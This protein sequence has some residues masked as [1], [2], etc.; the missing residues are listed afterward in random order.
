MKITSHILGLGLLLAPPALLG[1]VINAPHSPVAPQ[2]DGVVSPEEW[3]DAAQSY[4][5]IRYGK[6]AMEEAPTRLLVK[7][8]GDN[9]YIAA[10]CYQPDEPTCPVQ[11]RDVVMWLDDAVEFFLRPDLAKPD[12][13]HFSVNAIGNVY[14]AKERDNSWNSDAW[15]VKTSQA[16]GQW[17]ME[18]M[19]PAEV[20]GLSGGFPENCELGFNFCRNKSVDKS[21]LGGPS[22]C[23]GVIASTWTPY[24]SNTWHDPES[25]G[26][27]SGRTEVYFQQDNLLL[28]TASGIRITGTLYNPTDRAIRV[29]AHLEAVRHDDGTIRQSD[30]EFEVPA[31]ASLP[32]D[33]HADAGIGTWDGSFFLMDTASGQSYA[34]RRFRDLLDTDVRV[35]KFWSSEVVEAFYNP[36][37]FSSFPI[38]GCRFTLSGPDGKIAERDAELRDGVWFAEFDFHGLAPR[39]YRIDGEVRSADG[40]TQSLSGVGFSRPVP[41]AWWNSTDGIEDIVLAPWTPVQAGKDG[42]SVW[43]RSIHFG[44]T[45]FLASIVSQD[46]ELLAAP[47]ALTGTAEGQTIAFDAASVELTESR[48][49]TAV[50]RQQARS[51]K[52]ALDIT[53]TIEYDGLIRFDVK[54]SADAPQKLESLQL[55]IPFATE[56]SIFFDADPITPIFIGTFPYWD[57]APGG[58]FPAQE[59][60]GSFTPY[61]FV[62]NDEV[63]LTWVCEAPRHWSNRDENRVLALRPTPTDHRLVMNIV[64]RPVTLDQPLEFSFAVQPTP[65]KAIPDEFRKFGMYSFYGAEDPKLPVDTAAQGLAAFPVP[66]DVT[67]DAGTLSAAVAP[68]QDPDSQWC[69]GG[70]DPRSDADTQIL[71]LEFPNGESFGLY[72]GVTDAQF[73]LSAYTEHSRQRIDRID[74][75]FKVPG[76]K[77]GT[78]KTAEVAWHDGRIAVKIDGVTMAEAAFPAHEWFAEKPEQ[79]RITLGGGFRYRDFTAGAFTDALNRLPARCNNGKI[80]GNALE[81]PLAKET[82]SLL[83]LWNRSGNNLVHLHETWTESEGYPMTRKFENEVTRLAA[84]ANALDM[85]LLPYLGFQLGNN[86]PEYADYGEEI[87]NAPLVEERG[88]NRGDHLGIDICYAGQYQ[89]FIVYGVEKML[90]EYGIGGIYMDGTA[91]PPRCKN[92]RHGCGYYDRDGKLQP[93]YPIFEYRKLFKRLRTV[94]KKARPDF[95]M[96]MHT[97]IGIWTPIIGFGDTVWKGEQ[98]VFYAHDSASFR[99]QIKLDSIRAGMGRQYGLPMYFLNYTQMQD[100][101]AVCAVLNIPLRLDGGLPSKVMRYYGVNQGDFTPYWENGITGNPESTLAGCYRRADGTLLVPVADLGGGDTPLT[102]TLTFPET[103]LP[104]NAA[105]FDA[106]S[107]EALALDGNRLSIPLRPWR[108]RYILIADPAVQKAVE[109]GT[110]WPRSGYRQR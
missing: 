88:Y 48:D 37:D 103:L 13:Y 76:W 54:L 34:A 105:A 33:M 71:A 68:L 2:I 78:E 29:K 64:D 9:L 62:G 39:N 107:G 30:S 60:W 55:E 28:D 81:L 45:P 31:H 92:L 86:S 36:A 69:A 108:H 3:D 7:F 104:A 1:A 74:R 14:D 97:T 57:G 110:V 19:I 83:A 67:L 23:A 90:A 4:R 84:G 40:N 51:G 79:S 12:Y 106:I 59:A 38:Q 87:A 41:P 80:V 49:T 65:V 20:L 77:P 93:S 27:L 44:G 21:Q 50:Y 72:Y 66:G 26:V 22:N 47:I 75:A 96:D 35:K 82:I 58:S 15:Q 94:G 25:F 102:A 16:P 24:R 98:F 11:T 73:R 91:M 46:Q 43:G 18:A 42:F 32:V 70:R 53:T 109:P 95:W 5:F 52:M 10:I 6:T 8:H 85:Q 61:M 89:N 17:S 63:G 101:G 56:Q 99:E 100:A